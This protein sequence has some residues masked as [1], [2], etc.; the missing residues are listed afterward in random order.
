MSSY[1]FEPSPPAQPSRQ[2]RVQKFFRGPGLIVVVFTLAIAV[3]WFISFLTPEPV[4]EE[5]SGLLNYNGVAEVMDISEGP[6]KCHIYIKRDTGQETRQRM[7]KADCRK[8]RVG[9]MVN[10]ENGRYAGKV[11]NP[12]ESFS[13]APVSSP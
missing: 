12:Y 10:Y 13:R 7:A 3:W 1:T 2:S 11:P 9:D 8:V 6:S 5:G 4:H